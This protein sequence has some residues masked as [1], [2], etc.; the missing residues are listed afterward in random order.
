MISGRIIKGVGGLYF[1]DT[2]NGVYSCQA[3]GLFRK[4]KKTPLV[5]DFAEI[6][7]IDEDKKTGYLQNL[8]KRKN[9]L[10]RPRVANI[11]QAIIVFAAVS[12]DINIDLLDRF[13]IL[14]EK[15]QLDIIICINKTDLCD[16]DVYSG[17]EKLYSEAGYRIFS[18][19]AHD[20]H[21][22]DELKSVM[23]G[24]VS[25][26]AGP[27]GA[28][29]S[30]L[31]NAMFPH[32]NLETGEISK[33]IARGK[34]TTRHT[35]F[36]KIGAGGYIADTPGFTSLTVDDIPKNELQNY[37]IEFNDF[38]GKCRFND[39]I[40]IN[41]PDCAVKEQ[42]GLCISESRYNSYVNFYNQSE[43]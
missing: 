12:P 24:K 36:L 11:D 37:F 27:S 42:V 21:S 13:I 15:Q 22:L 29:K 10:F 16:S 35:E 8:L 32:I 43:Y 17:I 6:M 26:V 40:H 14:I 33:K 7:I 39:C 9:E 31:I 34:H 2:V 20:N 30:S 19:S 5:G 38:I 28:G 18:V 25:I 3:R 4:Q 41:E 1:V 23:D